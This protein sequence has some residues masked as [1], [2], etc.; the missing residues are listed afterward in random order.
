MDLFRFEPFI[1]LEYD[2][3]DQQ[4]LEE[5]SKDPLDN[6]FN[7]NITEI[8]KNSKKIDFN[9]SRYNMRPDLVAW[10]EYQSLALT[11]LIL[12]VNRCTTFLNF[13]RSNVGDTILVP[14]KLY[15]EK[16][17]NSQIN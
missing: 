13:T 1:P 6:I 8:R 9:S 3:L 15:I 11:N 17:L 14:D 12:L 16:L 10:D 2:G 5:L 7:M 4:V